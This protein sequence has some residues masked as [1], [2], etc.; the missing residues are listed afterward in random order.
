MYFYD[1]TANR[2]FIIGDLHNSIFIAN[3]FNKAVIFPK[4]NSSVCKVSAALVRQTF[5][6]AS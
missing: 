5:L 1:K 3:L 6:A 2:R 4:G